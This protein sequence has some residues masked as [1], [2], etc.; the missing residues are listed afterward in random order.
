MAGASGQHVDRDGRAALG[1]R[2][3]NRVLIVVP[4]SVGGVLS[5]RRAAETVAG[6]VDEVALVV[7]RV[8]GGVGRGQAGEAI[9]REV[10]GE[11]GEL[12]RVRA[13]AESGDLIGALSGRSS[14]TLA[15]RVLDWAA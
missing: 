6:V 10:I 8:R 7:R 14:R 11:L 15:R 12:P 2:T 13:A 1:W 3:L 9:G 5:A 4:D